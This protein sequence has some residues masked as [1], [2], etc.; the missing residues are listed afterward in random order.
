[1]SSHV[2]FL[3]SVYLVTGKHKGRKEPLLGATE[4]LPR[5][6][7]LFPFFPWSVFLSF[8]AFGLNKIPGATHH[9]EFPPNSVPQIPRS[10]CF[11]QKGRQ[12]TMPKK[13]RCMC[14]NFEV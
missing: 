11:K 2:V 5:A 12:F 14:E 3:V 13:I 8:L 6:C 10:C 7:Q 1:M 9:I 4:Q